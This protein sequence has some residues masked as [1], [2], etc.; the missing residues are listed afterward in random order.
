[1]IYVYTEAELGVL[2]YLATL[3]ITA[4]VTITAGAISVSLAFIV[5]LF[6]CCRRCL[7][8]CLT[9]AQDQTSHAST[10]RVPSFIG[11]VAFVSFSYPSRQFE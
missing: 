6:C 8:Y 5:S 11:F 2:A 3:G 9:K 10:N 7:R 1:M 4:S